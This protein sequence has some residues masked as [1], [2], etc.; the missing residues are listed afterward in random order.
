MPI[1]PANRQAVLT[2]LSDR[3]E[4]GNST[5]VAPVIDAS[6]KRLKPSGNTEI[7]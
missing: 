5:I 4:N 7:V 6:L 3:K 2:D 1:R